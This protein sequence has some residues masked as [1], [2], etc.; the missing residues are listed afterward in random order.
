MD[1][2]DYSSP[3]RTIGLLNTA[4][5]AICKKK[6]LAGTRLAF[7]LRNEY[8]VYYSFVMFGNILKSN[9]AGMIIEEC[10]DWDKWSTP[11]QCTVTI[12]QP[13]AAGVLLRTGLIE[14]IVRNLSSLLLLCFFFL[15]QRVRVRVRLKPPLQIHRPIGRSLSAGLNVRDFLT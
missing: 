8:V 13:Q 14:K 9:W 7:C 4:K 11:T 5:K 10:G 15:S 6:L 3:K 12:H 2:C 1:A